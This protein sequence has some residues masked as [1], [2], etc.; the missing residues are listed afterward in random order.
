MGFSLTVQQILAPLSN[1]GDIAFSIGLMVLLMVVT[2]V[3]MP[4]VLPL[5]LSGITITPGI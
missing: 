5:L 2:I 1:R 4:I 3:Y